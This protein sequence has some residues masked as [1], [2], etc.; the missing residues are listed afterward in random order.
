MVGVR[1]C[2]IQLFLSRVDY[3]SFLFVASRL[4]TLSTFDLT[5]TV[6]EV[7]NS[8]S[9][10]GHQ[11]D[12]YKRLCQ[13]AAD[14]ERWVC[15]WRKHL[16][17]CT[18]VWL[19]GQKNFRCGGLWRGLFVLPL[20]PGEA[21]VSLHRWLLTWALRQF[22]HED[23]GGLLWKSVT[24][25]VVFVALTCFTPFSLMASVCSLWY[26]PSDDNVWLSPLKGGQ[27][28]LEPW[29]NVL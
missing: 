2:P 14:L 27:L 29:L 1:L 22:A 19:L 5:C 23:P 25:L 18:L 8:E 4:S 10:K 12:S 15:N 20:T 21:A 7:V 6:I 16:K 17:L 11:S 3:V 13:S 26:T 28:P 9:C 24:V